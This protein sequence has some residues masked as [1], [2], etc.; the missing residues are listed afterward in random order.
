M[1]TGSTGGTV[2]ASAGWAL[3]ILQTLP[4]LAVAVLIVVLPDL[5]RVYADV[6]HADLWVP[7]VITIPAI[8]VA[9]FSGALGWCVDRFGR[10]VVLIPSLLVFGLCGIVP[11][12]VSDLP[13]V[14]VSRLFV[15]VGEA[16]ILTVGGTLIGDYFSGAEQRQ[17]LSRQQVIGPIANVVY[18][19]L[20]GWLAR[21][22]W[23][24]PF[25]IY[26]VGIG[27]LVLAIRYFP[28]PIR[29]ASRSE[30]DVPTTTPFPWAIGVPVGVVTVLTS[31]MFFI[32]SL[33]LGRIFDA[34]GAHAIETRTVVTALAVVCSVVA[35]ALYGMLRLPLSRYF[36]LIFALFAVS[37]VALPWV[38]DLR[39][40]VVLLGLGQMGAGFSI[41]VMIAWTLSRFPDAQR[42]RG[43]SLWAACFF[44]G[45]FV[46]PLSV[47]GLGH[48][49][50]SFLASISVL[51]VINAGLA[52]VAFSRPVA[53]TR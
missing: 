49:G 41:P 38:T 36:A 16:G 26:L 3:V 23:H 51:G 27:V 30:R 45:E 39:L 19:S 20:G 13:Q 47:A 4:T 50:L 15:G 7:M 24:Y 37:T 34:L 43:M 6:P 29:A 25:L 18:L 42:G 53:T 44:I 17:W 33:Q 12:V 46:S 48:T 1:T 35:G 10:R 8:C 21:Y 40:G 9:L 2:P 28:E 11:C 5:F 52:V 14:L 31:S 22:S 32:E